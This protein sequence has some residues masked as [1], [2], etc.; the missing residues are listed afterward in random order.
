MGDNKELDKYYFGTTNPATTAVT[1]TTTS[2]TSQAPT[3]TVSDGGTY[4]LA[5]VDKAGNRLL[6]I[7][8]PK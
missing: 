5:V 8:P 6:T 2:G 1:Y 4:Y 7:Y 3:T